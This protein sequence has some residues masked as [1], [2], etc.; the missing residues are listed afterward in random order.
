VSDNWL[1]YLNKYDYFFYYFC[2]NPGCFGRAWLVQNYSAVTGACIMIRKST[3]FEVNGLDE[4]NLTAA[5]NDVD[6]CIKVR[7]AGYRNLWS[8]FAELYHHE[9]ATRGSDLAPEKVERFN[10]E[11]AYMKQQHADELISDPAYN[12]NL[13]LISSHFA[14][15]FPPREQ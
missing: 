10:R 6:F 15:A 1:L 9:S 8:P 2:D 5:F 3:Y 4:E 14:L 12:P 11:V 13:D 7:N